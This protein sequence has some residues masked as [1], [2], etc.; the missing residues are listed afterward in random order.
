MHT[1]MIT[2]L[3]GLSHILNSGIRSILMLVFHYFKVLSN[4]YWACF[5]KT[6]PTPP[7]LSHK[8][9]PALTA[10]PTPQMSDGFWLPNV[11]IRQLYPSRSLISLFLSFF[12]IFKAFACDFSSMLS[13]WC[14]LSYLLLGC[15]IISHRQLKLG[16][17][18]WHLEM[19][20]GKLENRRA[21][22]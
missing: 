2:F 9:L 20:K 15:H 5:N 14:R 4:I 21:F 13:C 16:T 19:K 1:F 3:F 12:F 8:Y 6:S 18:E 10:A 11:N 7:L 22:E 17:M